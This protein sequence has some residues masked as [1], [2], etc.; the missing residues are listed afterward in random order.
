MFTLRKRKLLYIILTV[1]ALFLLA[2]HSKLINHQ[3]LAS[4]D[5]SLTSFGENF[6]FS[7]L[8][9]LSDSLKNTYNRWNLKSS[10]DSDAS[11]ASIIEP[12]NVQFNFI[13]K[14]K[15]KKQTREEI[16]ESNSKRYAELMNTEVGKPQ[17]ASLIPPPEDKHQYKRANATILALVRNSEMSKIGQSIRRFQKSF[18]GKFNYP[19]TF[20]NDEP[21]TERFKQKIVKY[22]EDAPVEFVTIKP[23]AWK[24]PSSIDETKEAQAMQ[25]MYDHNIAY[26]KQGSYHNMCRFYSGQFYNVPELQ[27]YKYYW[28]IEPQVNFYTDVTYD[29]FKY[30]ETTGKIYGFTVSLY[31]IEE[32]IKTLWPETLKYLNTGDNYKYVNPN[33]SFQ[34]LVED[35]QNPQKTKIAGGYSTCHFWSNFEIG[36][37]DFFRSDAYNNW[38]KYLDSTGGFYYERWGDAP[39]HSIGVSLFADKSKIHWFRDLGYNHDPY[40]NCAN[41]PF[42]SHC[43]AGKFSRYEHL[44]DQNCLMNWLEYDGI[45][46]VYTRN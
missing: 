13:H 22:T 46:D 45:K 18:N 37:M 12:N 5:W 30:M 20:I 41:T 35:L 28:R 39:V 3:Q 19:Y 16:I 31:D 14:N 1:T 11:I 17:D 26:A 32:S 15:K 34:W 9:N 36:D 40:Y 44:N 2:I 10:S 6:D 7:Y 42:T 23:E 25:V 43:V 27:K 4:H 33:G 8:P 29:V 38:F 24:K 21:F